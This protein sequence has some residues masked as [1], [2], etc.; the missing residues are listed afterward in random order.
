LKSS[1]IEDSRRRATLED[2]SGEASDAN[3]LRSTRLMR[4]FIQQL[5]AIQKLKGKADHNHSPWNKSTC[6]REGRRS[7]DP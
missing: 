6:I 2:Q 5:E 1:R 7:W 4:V 3:V